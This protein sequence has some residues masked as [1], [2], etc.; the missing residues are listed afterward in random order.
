[1]KSLIRGLAAAVLLALAS[2]AYAAPAD[3]T[4]S[5]YNPDAGSKQS[6]DACVIQQSSDGVTADPINSAHPL[7]VTGSVSVTPSGTQDVNTKQVNGTTTSTGAG[8]TGAGSQRVT[9]AQDSTTVCGSAPGTAGTPSSNV[10]TVQNVSSGTG[11]DST[12]RSIA[13]GA[14]LSDDPVSG[15]PVRAGV[16]ARTSA[17]TAVANDDTVDLVASTQGVLATIHDSTGADGSSNTVGALIDRNGSAIRNLSVGVSGFN[18]S[19]W[20]RFRTVSIGN[21]VAATGIAAS[22]AYGQYLNNANQPAITTGNY[23]ALQFAPDG[24]LRTTGQRPAT[25]DILDG[26]A[27]VTAT[28]GTTTLITVSAGRTWIGNLCASVDGNKA[29]AATGNG[30][31]N[32]T[33]LTTGTG[34][35]PAAGTYWGLGTS[36]GANAATGTVGTQSANANC[37][38]TFTTTAPAGNSTTINYATT[39]T[40]TTACAAHVSAIGNLQ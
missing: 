16:R 12:G 15:A 27:T 4:A 35:T 1:M 13:V 25:G 34:V 30:L 24:A 19:L 22:G 14:A 3:N 39:C 36:I 21:N 26:Y 17:I 20:D 40:S 6:V 32:A 23:G 5:H 11:S 28:T 31:V 10:I 18:G 8:A 38:P 29:A 2:Q 37:S 33:F 9:A 7:A